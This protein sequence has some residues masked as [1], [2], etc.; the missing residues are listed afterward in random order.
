MRKKKYNVA[1]RTVSLCRDPGGN[2]MTEYL[3]RGALCFPAK[4]EAAGGEIRIEGYALLAGRD[5]QGVVD[6]FEEFPWS[7]VDDLIDPAYDM[8]YRG[9]GQ[10]LIRQWSE[11]FGRDYYWHQGEEHA[12]RYRIEIVR[13]ELIEP[14]PSFIA[15]PW[16]EQAAADQ[17]LLMWSHVKSRKLILLKNGP[18][19]EQLGRMNRGEGIFHPAIHALQ[20]LLLGYERYGRMIA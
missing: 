17:D 1:R 10:W 19:F 16:P 4:Y 6:I 3:V 7:T 2:E 12:K 20:C 5:R 9:L 14:K 15:V 11:Y 8:D 13:S 18:L